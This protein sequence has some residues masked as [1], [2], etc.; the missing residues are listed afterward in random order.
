MPLQELSPPPRV[1]GL[2]NLGAIL[3]DVGSNIERTREAD[4]LRAESRANQLAD[5]ASSRTF[6]Q[7]EGD[8]QYARSRADQLADVQS[9][10]NAQLGL[11]GLEHEWRRDDES[12][13]RIYAEGRALAEHAQKLKEF[14]PDKDSAKALSNESNNILRGVR[15]RAEELQRVITSEPRQVGA[16]DPAVMNL[17]RQMAGSDKMDIIQT[18][19]PKALEQLNGEALL[20]H[21]FRTRAAQEALM[22]LKATEQQATDVIQTIMTK[23]GVVPEGAPPGASVL[24]QPTAAAA[25]VGPTITPQSFVQGSRGEGQLAS[26]NGQYDT[27]LTPAE[28]QQFQAWKQRYAPND[29][30]ADYDLR[31]AFKAGIT[32][33]S[34]GHWPDTFKKP[35]HPTFSNESK[36]ASGAP[37]R[38]GRW[39][40]DRYISP[41]QRAALTLAD[42]PAG[43]APEDLA[44]QQR[45]ASAARTAAQATLQATLE[46]ETRK[47]QDIQ[48]Q[49]ARA[50]ARARPTAG[51]LSNTPQQL[52]EENTRLLQA[53]AAQQQ[54]VKSLIDQLQG[55]SPTSVNTQAASIPTFSFGATGALAPSTVPGQ[56]WKTPAGL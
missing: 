12:D 35:N 24:A 41:A 7:Q 23:F 38:A 26:S 1:T 8:R 11:L 40:R 29:S 10:R 15:A 33:S 17:A 48:Q 19:I 18:M 5:V 49:L 52:A 20:R 6:S 53:S 34:N 13:A 3:A 50:R 22:S 56:W 32:P 4:R 14:Q 55:P 16:N 31:G 30:G 28:E 2:S 21:Q 51:F 47:F 9:S 25:P 45:G 39:V 37:D 42:L 36:Y 46:D 54:K 44:I 27:V 43:A